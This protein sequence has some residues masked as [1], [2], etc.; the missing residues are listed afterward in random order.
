MDYLQW[1][2]DLSVGVKAF[3]E[4]HRMLVDFINRLNQALIVGDTQTAV[5][6]I[7]TGLV[8]YTIT[9]FAAEEELMTAH[10]Y[11][12]YDRHKKEHD[13]LTAQVSDYQERFNS[14][15]VKF[16]L[17]LIQFLRDWLVKHIKGSDKSYREF[18]SGKG[19]V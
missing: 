2:E 18:F 13:S 11:P 17:E 3:D 10:G 5:A 8:K 9:H 6:D 4:Q 16:S 7:L 15:R 12:D 19:I 14:G 1:T